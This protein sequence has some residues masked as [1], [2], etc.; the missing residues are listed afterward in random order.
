[1]REASF[2]YSSHSSHSVLADT[3]FALLYRVL[4]RVLYC[5]VSSV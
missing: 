5:I 4:Y 3:D 2:H 1:M